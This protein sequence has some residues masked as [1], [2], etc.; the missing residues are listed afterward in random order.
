MHNVYLFQ[1]QYTTLI[2]GK[3][4]NWLP[5]AVG[6]IWSYAAQF[7][8][9][10]NNFKLKD[11]IFKREKINSLLDRIESPKVCGFSCYLWNRK[12]C[13]ALAEAVK[14]R[15]PDC[16][17]IFGG[18]EV[19]ASMTKYDFID[20]ILIGEGEENF[21]D[22]L[23]NILHNREPDLFFP[24]KRLEELN[25]P[26]PYLTGVFDQILADNPDVV[27]AVTIETNRGCPYS[28]TFCDWGSLTYSKVKKFDL[29]KIFAE[30]TWL[31]D[32]P[33]AYIYLADANFGMYKQRDIEIAK[34][35]RK[36]ADNPIVELI[37][38]QGAKN[39]TE[40]AFQIG[41][42]LG[43][44][45][46]GVTVSVQSMNDETLGLIKR[47]NMPTNNIAQLLDL[48]VK[49]NI[50]T[51]TEM[52]LGMPHETKETWC[53]G[54]TDLLEI[55]QHNSIEMWFTQLL[56]NSELS[57]PESRKTYGIKS[58]TS[59]NYVGMPNSIDQDGIDEETEIICETN[60]MPMSDMIDSYMY[61]WM[62]LQLH[63]P[64]YSQ[65]LAKYLRYAKNISFRQFY[66]LLLADILN[67]KWMSAEY[68]RIRQ[69]VE[70]FLTTGTV[71][72]RY[73]TGHLLYGASNTWIYENKQAIIDFVYQSASKLSNI[74]EWV[75]NLQKQFIYD[76]GVAYPLQI[77]ADYNI[78][79]KTNNPIVYKI[80]SKLSKEVN[81]YSLATIRR[82][83][84]LKNSIKEYEF[85]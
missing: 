59:S 20:C 45:Y 30:I 62:I 50:P 19:S 29:E 13:L 57:Q 81:N 64:G 18:P 53:K 43:P 28:C 42:I 5:Y 71:D 51:Y 40:I 70:K 55:G 22:I 6:S 16:V 85:T 21:V 80:D 75:L 11:L 58:I 3:I 38:V 66:D 37:S 33:I 1:P 60:T 41:E 27:W 15:W 63:I 4:N 31:I 74:P 65:I 76:S 12:Y 34:M 39:N 32:K 69:L 26:S 83:G 84:V 23:R 78:L 49:Y 25:I 61:G 67:N 79:K 36:A 48:S 68:H 82:K 35:L 7:E 46:T 9:I 73:V 56:A 17:I 8:D 72:D 52:I 24:K 2:N 10:F 47:K 54:M 77:S 44:K 14:Q